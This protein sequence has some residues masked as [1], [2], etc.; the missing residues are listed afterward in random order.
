MGSQLIWW[1]E[2]YGDYN[3]VKKAKDFP[4]SSHDK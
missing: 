1:W 2:K 3:N 4:G